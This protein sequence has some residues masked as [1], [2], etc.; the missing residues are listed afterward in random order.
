MS[1]AGQIN[2]YLSILYRVSNPYFD[3]QLSSLRIGC[4][5]QFFLLNIYKHP[6][7]SFQRLASEGYYDKATATRAVKKLLQEG[8]V[9]QESDEADKRLKHLYITEKAG[10]II[11]AT[12]QV[13][14]QWLGV[15]TDG[16][17]EEEI[18]QSAG[19]LERM[20][21]NAR[22]YMERQKMKD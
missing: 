3:E 11:Q 2:R 7:I 18:H 9:R 12:Y 17:T 4:G 6:G 16:F 19:F 20:A 22:L 21:L 13:L 8:Y 1:E 14:E 10:P 5:Q 15:I